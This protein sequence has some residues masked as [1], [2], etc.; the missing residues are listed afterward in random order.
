MV[1]LKLWLGGLDIDEISVIWSTILGST[2][3]RASRSKRSVAV[4]RF[5]S[6]DSDATVQDQL[7]FLD[8]G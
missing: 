6:R 4:R 2:A 5:S 8:A 1:V 3:V 7:E